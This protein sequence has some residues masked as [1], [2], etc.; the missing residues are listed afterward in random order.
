MGRIRKHQR[1]AGLTLLAHATEDQF[2]TPYAARGQFGFPDNVRHIEPFQ[3]LDLP[4]T[5]ANKVMMARGMKFKPACMALEFHLVNKTCFYQGV[6]VAIHRR[7]RCTRVSA[8]DPI[9][10]FVG[11]WMGRMFR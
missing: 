2:P 1:S 6:E 5:F 7:A 10:N 8:V 11:G 4:A 3:V 9:V